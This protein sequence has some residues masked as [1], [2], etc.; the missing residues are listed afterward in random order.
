M[1]AASAGRPGEAAERAREAAGILKGTGYTI[2]LGRALDSLGRSSDDPLEALEALEAALAAF[3]TC[4]AEW[5]RNRTVE[6]L[7]GLGRPGRRSAAAA[8]RHALLTAR[9]LEVARLAARRLTAPEIAREL[10]ISRRTVE[11]HL[12]NVYGKLGVHSKQEVSQRASAL[13]LF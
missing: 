4:Q 11:G 6:A 12:A 7:R 10:F 5:H 3:D 13:G 9:E 2:L 1:A 8:M